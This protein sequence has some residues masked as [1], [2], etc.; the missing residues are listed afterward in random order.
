[1]ALTRFG[2]H[3]ASLFRWADVSRERA[4]RFL[5]RPDAAIFE[6]E[7]RFRFAGT[8]LGT[9]DHAAMRARLAD[10]P[11]AARVN[12]LAFDADG[13]SYVHGVQLGREHA[14]RL[15]LDEIAAANA[16]KIAHLKRKFLAELTREAPVAIRLEWAPVADPA[17]FLALGAALRA[18]SAKAR[19]YVISPMGGFAGERAGVGFVTLSAPLPPAADVMNVAATAPEFAAFFAAWEIA[20]AGAEKPYIFDI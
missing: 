5:E 6:G 18:L 14:A 19:L 4:Q 15:S 10:A 2:H 3:E 16:Q 17:P 9:L 8:S 11:A 13:T 20:P 1:M 12:T 7:T